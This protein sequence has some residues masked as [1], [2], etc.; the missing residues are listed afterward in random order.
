MRVAGRSIAILGS[1][2]LAG[3]AA[4]PPEGPSVMAL[5]GKDKSFEAFEADD[6]ACK[7]YALAQIGFASPA[8]AASG[9]AAASA[10]L[11]TAAGAAAGAAIGAATGNP[12][13]GA[14]VGAGSGLLLGGATGVGAAETSRFSLQRRYDIAYVQCMS[15]KG[16]N[17][18]A[19][20]VSDTGLHPTYM[21]PYN[22]HYYPYYAPY[23]PY[24][25]S[26]Y[27][28]YPFYHYPY[29]PPFFGHAFLD[30]GFGFGHRHHFVHARH[31]VHAPHA[32]HGWS[33]GHGHR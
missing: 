14:A 12:G 23:Y 29:Y 7:Q 19:I 24:S 5:P 17:V 27:P 1:L 32:W 10:A 22:L 16:E 15:A 28:Y 31:F 20:T 6:T 11:G 4:A 26:Y 2:A 3:C 13:T 9:S 33:G 25:Y 21:Y 18:P 8:E 30:L